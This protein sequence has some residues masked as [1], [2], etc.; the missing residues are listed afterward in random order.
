MK[1]TILLASPR[2]QSLA[3]RYGLFASFILPSL[4]TLLSGYSALQLNYFALNMACFAL[5]FT[6]FTVVFRHFLRKSLTYLVRSWQKTALTVPT[7]LLAYLAVSWLLG[8]LITRLAPEFAN[9]NDGGVATLANTN[10]ILTFIATVFLVPLAEECVFRAG[11]FGIFYR[12]NRAF[13]YILSTVLFALIHIDGFFGLADGKLLILSFL[14][15]LPAGVAL[16]AA[17]DI[18]GTVF[19]PIL[20]HMAVNAIGMLALR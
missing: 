4:L 6:F 18:S 3:V 7:L 17:Y 11:L 14:Q 2:E 15:Y 19:A 12:N 16:G 1:T 8:Q 9:Q 20:I 10:Y 13:A 5:N